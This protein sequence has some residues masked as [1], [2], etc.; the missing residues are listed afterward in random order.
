MTSFQSHTSSVILSFE[1]QMIQRFMKLS[2]E[3]AIIIGNLYIYY[4]IFEDHLFVF[5]EVFSENSVRVVSIFREVC[6]KEQVM[7]APDF[8]IVICVTYWNSW[9]TKRWCTFIHCIPYQRNML[10][11]GHQLRNQGQ[12]EYLYQI[13]GALTPHRWRYRARFIKWLNFCSKITK[14]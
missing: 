3:C 1:R 11:C 5:N 12:L 8:L 2:T 13:R 14:L 7:M 9:K 10:G 6:N 4:P